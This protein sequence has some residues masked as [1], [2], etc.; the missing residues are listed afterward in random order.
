MEF[1]AHGQ[2]VVR[3]MD[4]DDRDVASPSPPPQSVAVKPGGKGVHAIWVVDEA[5]QSRMKTMSNWWILN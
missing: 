2:M 3:N 5:K 1:R 4:D